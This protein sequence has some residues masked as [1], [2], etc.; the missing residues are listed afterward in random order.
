MGEYCR[1]N[2]GAGLSSETAGADGSNP[3]GISGAAGQLVS[4]TVGGIA[5]SAGVT[6]VSL[7]SAGIG[8]SVT[9]LP[10][11]AGGAAVPQ[12]GVSASMTTAGAPAAAEPCAPEGAMRCSPGGTNQREKCSDRR[13]MPA[14]AC[15][16]SETCTS[17][18]SC[19][20]IAELC[21]GS[22]G[23]AVC[24]SQ[25]AMLQCNTD[26]TAGSP[27]MCMS[28]AHCRAGLPSRTCATCLPN[29]HHCSG[30]TLEV[31]GTDGMSYTRVQDCN[32]P[33]LCNELVGAC[34]TATCE[35]NKFACMGNTLT[36][37]DA[38]GT[39][40]VSQT[41]CGSGTCDATGGDC[42]KCQPGETTCDKS[43]VLTC[44]AD[45]QGYDTSACPNNGKCQ[46]AGK[47]VACIADSDCPA[48]SDAC[49]LPDCTSDNRCVTMSAADRKTCTTLLSTG[50]C[51]GGVCIGCIDDVDCGNKIGTPSCDRLQHR[52]V[53]CVDAS[54]CA[55]FAGTCKK[56]VCTNNTCASERLTG[57]SCGFGLECKN[58][59]CVTQCGNGKI[60]LGEDCEMSLEQPRERPYCVNCHWTSVGTINCQTIDDCPKPRRTE[61]PACP[62]TGG[63]AYKCYY[64]CGTVGGGECPPGGTCVD[65]FACKF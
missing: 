22:A 56:A 19:R 6:G 30:A 28:A 40:F 43:N 13:W 29:A 60:D 20:P 58:G 54:Q 63:N 37:C 17:D 7:G 36:K 64:G 9:G 1:S 2:K 59:D 23:Q 31:C 55:K 27:Q 39:G 5:G 65:N 16:N 41:P 62:T 38:N 8:G 18:G 42:N 35:A 44:K 49:Q 50:V 11:T 26:G 25:G 57:T 53:E 4:G 33:G 47:C 34:T 24:D 14:G 45:G 61:N 46:G 15:A 10:S 12:A 3:F 21:R 48:S 51:S 32:N 52:C